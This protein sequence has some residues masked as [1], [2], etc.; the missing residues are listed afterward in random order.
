M[1]LRH[2]HSPY[3][4]KL[5]L[6]SAAVLLALVLTTF[7]LRAETAGS[8]G[9]DSPGAVPAS[10]LITIGPRLVPVPAPPPE[11]DVPP[12]PIYF[13]PYPGKDGPVGFFPRPSA[14]ATGG[15]ASPAAA[16]AASLPVQPPSPLATAPLPAPSPPVTAEAP[17]LPS[18]PEQVHVT[19]S[20]DTEML[21]LGLVVNDIQMVEFVT[22]LAWH[23]KTL[24]GLGSLAAAL[25]F[26]I[27]VSAASQSA[28]GWYVRERNAFEVK[29]HTV[30]IRGNDH[31]LA[32]D[33][34]VIQDDDIFIDMQR[35][36]KLM[37]LRFSVDLP[38]MMLT[39]E[40]DQPLPFEERI[41]RQQ[42]QLRLHSGAP[43]V[44]STYPRVTDPYTSFGFPFF[45]FTMTSA[46]RN[47]QDARYE[48]SY[49]LLSKGDLAHM[50]AEV[51]L[52]GDL[53]A[54]TIADSHL[55]FGRTD[56]SRHLLGR[57]AASQF[58]F[59]DID[60]SGLTLVANSSVGRG[61]MVSNRSIYRADQFD[62]VTFRGTVPPGW[63]VEL[64]RNGAL[65]DIV[66]V[67]GDG[68]Y[69][70]VDVPILFGRNSFRTVRYGPQGEVEEETK[71]YYAGSTLLEAGDATY[72]L[73]LS[74]NNKSLLGIGD[75]TTPSDGLRLLGEAEY[76]VSK[77]LT[78][79]AGVGQIGQVDNTYRY[80]TGGVRSSVWG[81]LGSLDAAYDPE[82]SASAA[83]ISLGSNFYDVD[84]RLQHTFFDGLIS[85][86]N[87]NLTR[88][89]TQST[90]IDIDSFINL[91]GNNPLSLGFSVLQNRFENGES[92]TILRSR[93]SQ[94]FWG[95]S[96]TSNMERSYGSNEQTI[97]SVALRG[98]VRRVLLGVAA[99]YA[100][101]PESELRQ[102]NLT[103]QFYLTPN[104]LNRFTVSTD[105]QG[106]YTYSNNLVLDR[107]A[108]SLSLFAGNDDENAYFFGAGLNVSFTRLPGGH[109][110]FQS[111]AMADS[112][113]AAAR[114][115]LDDNANGQR[116]DGE[117]YISGVAFRQN[118][119][120]M[121]KTSDDLSFIAPLAPDNPVRISIDRENN[122]NPMRESLF[123]GYEVLPRPGHTTM[124][125]LPVV[126][127]SLVEG[128]LSAQ[129]D[130]Q[131]VPASR[132]LVELVAKNGG[133]VTATTSEFDGYYMFDKV[134]PG[135]YTL[136][137]TAPAT[138]VLVGQSATRVIDVKSGEF[139]TFDLPLMPNGI[140]PATSHKLE[141]PKNRSTAQADLLIQW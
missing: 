25:E 120:P 130:G 133:A 135:S 88:P 132:M 59:G 127:V 103:G 63:D 72:N 76:G 125:E 53:A 71:E 18:P 56:E 42:R 129:I 32:E 45:D 131:A 109:W 66:T 77:W 68:Q 16:A 75:S 15:V 115:F 114:A 80:L 33:E 91:L 36:G 49:S 6:F 140:S 64:Y 51:F 97:G 30:R 126:E 69:E 124:V 62:V 22:S 95:L 102:L 60:S 47:R 118:G 94:S 20:G 23:G 43:E 85:D 35:L 99:D 38:K 5:A 13:E 67:G 122:D 40:S 31:P 141:Q 39:I 29:D 82:R 139:Y 46:Y 87:K 101:E 89:M 113:G 1:L 117:N 104:I 110:H 78:V 134:T 83:R 12:L 100:I 136:R 73:S 7:S 70:F 96:L 57:L 28:S 11:A 108:Y 27:K 54:D 48:S 84:L 121:V 3:W 26:P 92:D 86:E 9:G 74:D 10:E 37:D 44:A 41:R 21:V 17:V 90:A 2:C 65:L 128:R 24:V 138:S 19:S 116:D 61:F 107:R 34:M 52:S 111:R 106:A 98:S 81:I 50:T 14:T 4:G 105:A 123:D 55:K 93:A 79:A 58:E 112:G 137:V 119:V 8:A